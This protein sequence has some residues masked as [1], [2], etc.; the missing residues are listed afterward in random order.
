MTASERASRRRLRF[1][2]AVVVGIF[3]IFAARLFQIQ[4]LDAS[5]YAAKAVDAGTNTSTVPAPRGQILDRN[6]V[7]LATGVDGLTLTA[8]PT[9]TTANAPRI[10]RLLVEHLGAMM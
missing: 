7:A 3:G 9:M 5:A 10:A 6:G 1:C 4:G 2:L 8:D